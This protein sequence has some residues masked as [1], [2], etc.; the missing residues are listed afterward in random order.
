MPIT[1]DLEL[2]I[3][4][5]HI[6]GPAV[7]ALES[8]KESDDG[9]SEEQVTKD[10]RKNLN[11]AVKAVKHLVK[12]I[13]MTENDIGIS[14]RDYFA[15]HALQALIS[16]IPSMIPNPDYTLEKQIALQAYEFADNMIAASK[17]D[18]ND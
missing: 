10:A 12:E 11:A 1:H 7:D 2:P 16:A 14:K 18:L 8:R 9:P 5:L 4:K 13:S 17:E 6:T 3:E 15:A